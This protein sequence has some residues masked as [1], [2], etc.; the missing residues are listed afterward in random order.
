MMMLKRIMILLNTLVVMVKDMNTMMVMIMLNTMG[1][2]VILNTMM[3][4]VINFW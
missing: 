4:M 3:V 2:M 1:V